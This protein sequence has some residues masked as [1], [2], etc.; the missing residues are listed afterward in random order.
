MPWLTGKLDVH[1]GVVELPSIISK[2]KYL[3]SHLA[4]PCPMDARIT[5]PE[6]E[7]NITRRAIAAIHFLE[8]P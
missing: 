8:S 4:D 6:I 7:K 2:P 5:L 1:Y 3:L